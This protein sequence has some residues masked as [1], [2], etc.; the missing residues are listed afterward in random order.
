VHPD[1]AK[2]IAAT[3]SSNLT[4]ITSQYG[5]PF[6]SNAFSDWFRKQCD[7]AGLPQC[8]AHGL[9]KACARRLAEAGCTPHEI[10]S[11]TGHRTLAE[12]ERYTK[13]ARQSLM[14]DS[15]TAK[16]LRK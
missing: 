3:P 4:F 14:A 9:R 1:L 11:I 16:L 15:A 12:V 5:R 6:T 8:S 7:K 13:A 10:M 2:I